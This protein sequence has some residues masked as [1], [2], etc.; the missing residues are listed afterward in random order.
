M[1]A[2]KKST[3]HV[4]AQKQ[5]GD[6]FH[7]QRERPVGTSTRFAREN[8]KPDSLL[9]PCYARGSA[10]VFFAPVARTIVVYLRI[11]MNSMNFDSVSL[12]R[13]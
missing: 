8:V 7:V 1:K 3:L 11:V 10:T 6:G 2:M 9:V 5:P 13:S 12:S 4:P